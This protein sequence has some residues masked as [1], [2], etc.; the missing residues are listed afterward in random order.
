MIIYDHRPPLVTDPSVL[1]LI[2][3]AVG[4]ATTRYRH[5]YALIFHD[6]QTERDP[7]TPGEKQESENPVEA[8]LGPKSAI[9]Q[10]SAMEDDHV[11]FGYNFT[12]LATFPPHSGMKS[13]SWKNVE[14]FGVKQRDMIYLNPVFLDGIETTRPGSHRARLLAILYTVVCHE[15]AHLLHFKIYGIADDHFCA[16]GSSQICTE[17]GTELEYRMY[18]GRILTTPDLTG[19]R[20]ETRDG[21]VYELNTRYFFDDFLESNPPAF[22]FEK[23]Q[24]VD[25]ES[26]TGGATM[27]MGMG[28]T[29]GTHD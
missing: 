20:V 28:E 26:N 12:T 17:Y 22:D 1:A 2:V 29:N 5:H 9:S 24:T 15:L 21:D 13:Y 3:V 11:N 4:H 27:W 6:R 19:L 23:L 7:S 14:S 18:G 10:N 8:L 16:N 25:A